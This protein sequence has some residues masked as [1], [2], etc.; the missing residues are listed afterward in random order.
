MRGRPRR[1]WRESI[2]VAVRLVPAIAVVASA[3]WAAGSALASGPVAAAGPS[4]IPVTP[5]SGSSSLLTRAPY[6]TDLTQTG[7]DVN[8][9]TTSSALGSLEWGPLGSCTANKTPVPAQ[10]PNSYPAAGTPPSITQPEFNVVSGTNEY[11]STVVLTGLSPGTTYCYRPLAAGG[12]DLL[13]SNPSQQFT[14]LDPACSST[15]LTFDVV[16]DIGETLYSSTTAFPNNLNVDQAA[17]DS[18][19]GSSGAKFVVTAGDVAY[20]GGTQANY[21]DLV[22]GGSETSDIFGPSYWPQTKGLPVFPGE[23]NHGQNTIGLRTW[24]AS[25]TAA[26]S[27][28]TYAYD[29]Y[30]ANSQDGTAAGTYPDAWY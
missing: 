9:A 5:F 28:G 16:G 3:A 17:I 10:L 20:S 22:N 19:I 27:G 12:T 2:R 11:Q 4:P 29:S 15:P 6:V 26:A 1:K 30:P 24:P 25:N 18:L 23:G 14:T 13:G 21:G 7:A 8:W